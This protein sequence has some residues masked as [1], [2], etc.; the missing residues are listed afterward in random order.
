M[1][2]FVRATGDTII[3]QLKII[4]CSC[5]WSRTRFTLDEAYSRSVREVFVR[6]WEEKLIYRGHRVIHWCP[7]CLTALSDEEAEHHE[8]SGNLYHIKYPLA[9]GSGSVTVATTR[10]ETM[11]GDIGL[12]F[13]P[14]DARYKGLK[15]KQ[16]ND[17]ALRSRDS[18]RHR[19]GSGKGIRDRHAQGDARARRQRFRHRQS[20]V[21]RCRQAA[22]P[23]RRRSHGE[24]AA[25]AG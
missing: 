21:A 10:P 7:H 5:D 3:E 18:H 20:R 19:R 2:A 1:W 22:D 8:T 17:P 4:G 15:G 9:D 12:V 14:K 6:L 16:V 24:V 23:D 25:R 13:H 11:F